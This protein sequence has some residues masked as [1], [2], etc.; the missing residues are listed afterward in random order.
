VWRG[1][2]FACSHSEYLQVKRQLMSETQGP[3]PG[4]AAD[5][6]AGPST[7]RSWQDLSSEEQSKLLKERLKKYTQKVR[8]EAFHTLQV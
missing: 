5:G 4:A 2:H 6:G 1:E 3:A 8:P 7:A